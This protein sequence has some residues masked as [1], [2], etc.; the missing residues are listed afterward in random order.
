MKIINDITRI[1][2]ELQVESNNF[3]PSFN[4]YASTFLGKPNQLLNNHKYF[5]QY[6]P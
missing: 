1:L 4:T 2:L 5:F 3:N 6:L